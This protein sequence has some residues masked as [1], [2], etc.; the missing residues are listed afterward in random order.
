MVNNSVATRNNVTK[1][2]DMACCEAGV[3]ILVQF[4]FR[5][6]DVGPQNLWAH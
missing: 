6:G 5:E 2:V 1:L 4:L 3:E